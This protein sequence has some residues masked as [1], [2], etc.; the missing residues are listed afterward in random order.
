MLRICFL[1]IFRHYAGF[2]ICNGDYWVKIYLYVRGHDD[3]RIFL[4]RHQ[5]ETLGDTKLR[6]GELCHCQW[7]I[8]A[9]GSGMHESVHPPIWWRQ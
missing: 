5:K 2:Y 9:P 6:L 8:Y 1:A 4:G 3:I 7:G